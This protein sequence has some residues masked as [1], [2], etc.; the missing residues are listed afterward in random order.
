M[1]LKKDVSLG[2]NGNKERIFVSV[3]YGCRYNCRYCYLNDMGINDIQQI[4]T[5]E[6]LLDELHRTGIYTS[7]RNGNTISFGCYTECLDELSRGTC[8]DLM[9]Y[10]LKQGNYV[11]ISTKKQ[12]HDDELKFLAK[13]IQFQDQMNIYVS[14]PT[15]KYSTIYE[16]NAEKVEF[17]IRNLNI[18]NKF[19]IN[20][21]LYIKPVIEGITIQDKEKYAEL[22]EKHKIPVVIGD[23]LH[24][25]CEDTG[26]EFLLG[27]TK[28]KIYKNK[29][30]EKL[31]EYLKEYAPVYNH[32]DDFIRQMKTRTAKEDINGGTR[33]TIDR[34]GNRDSIAERIAVK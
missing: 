2:I 18:K 31:K 11:Q 30:S 13:N 10:F 14:L 23:M 9:G 22:V 27:K 8:I 29:D 24:P 28:M 34:R 7:G 17:R 12:I 21:F 33:F 25:T 20:T 4:F 15:L 3:T 16:P 6:D 5:K 26:N 19:N 32:S 1:I